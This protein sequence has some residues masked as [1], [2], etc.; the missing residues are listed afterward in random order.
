MVRL[1]SLL[2]SSP[3]L[4]ALARPA[5]SLYIGYRK[6]QELELTIQDQ[7]ELERTIQRLERTFRE[8]QRTILEL[9]RPTQDIRAIAKVIIES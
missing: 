9:E 8:S 5:E 1:N 3:W 2:T 6:S 7:G 4:E